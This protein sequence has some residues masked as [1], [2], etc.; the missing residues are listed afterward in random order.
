M[1][2]EEILHLG[3]LSR[4]ALSDN[5]VEELGR[6]I[7]N[8]IEYVSAVTAIAGEAATQ[9][10]TPVYNVARADEVTNEP[11]AYTDAILEQAPKRDNN[12]FVVKKILSTDE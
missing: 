1:T 11:G 5:E 9:E 12:H 8:I 4:I 2:K 7:T 10:L 3:Q 6:D